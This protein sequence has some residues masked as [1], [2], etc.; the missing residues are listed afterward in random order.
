MKSRTVRVA[1]HIPPYREGDSEHVLPLRV[2]AKVNAE[3]IAHRVACAAEL[4]K[5]VVEA[6][7]EELLPLLA[8]TFDAGRRQGHADRDAA[9]EG[10]IRRIVSEALEKLPKFGEAHCPHCLG[11]GCDECGGSGAYRP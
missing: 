3:G 6:L 1:A 9:L 8:E 10:T 4:G 7:T 5:C 11:S 2:H